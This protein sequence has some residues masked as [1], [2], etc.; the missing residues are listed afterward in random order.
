MEDQG[1]EQYE[2]DEALF[3]LGEMYYRER[4]L[5]TE[6]RK[7]RTRLSDY[8]ETVQD[9][10]WQLQEAKEGRDDKVQTTD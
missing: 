8:A 6:I 5:T 10:A 4:T 9:L 1:G 2:I 3:M 7:L